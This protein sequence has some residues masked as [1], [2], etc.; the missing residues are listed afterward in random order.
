MLAPFL[1][2]SCAPQMRNIVKED[3]FTAESV[4]HD[5]FLF[6]GLASEKGNFSDSEFSNHSYAAMNALTNS[7]GD[8]DISYKAN[9]MSDLGVD[10]FKNIVGRYQNRE[11]LDANVI[12]QISTAAAGF[13]YLVL[14]RIDQDGVSENENYSDKSTTFTV[15]RTL[16]VHTEIYD[17]NNAKL[18]WSGNLN[19]EISRTNTNSH[20]KSS[21]VIKDLLISA[22]EN[23]MYGKYPPPPDI[24]ELIEKSFDGIG[25]NLPAPTCDEVGYINCVKRAVHITN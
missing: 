1:L 18:V 14:S 25:K 22:A 9:F 11:I 17:F 8:I 12:S 23:K 21:N 3:S 13:R 15:K 16:G 4:I 20:N 10:N 7:R 6:L 5:R 2:L 19:T 24:N